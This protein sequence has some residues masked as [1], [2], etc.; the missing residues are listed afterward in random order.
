MIFFFVFL[1]ITLLSFAMTCNVLRVLRRSFNACQDIHIVIGNEVNII[2][3][4][5]TDFDFFY[6][7]VRHN[8]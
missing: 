7:G 6:Y 2:F 8:V 1:L 3:A 4:P 5:K